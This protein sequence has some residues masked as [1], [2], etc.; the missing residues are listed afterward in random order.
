MYAAIEYS[1]MVLRRN[2]ITNEMRSYNTDWIVNIEQP[3]WE[4]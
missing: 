4:D 1:L 2:G 3:K